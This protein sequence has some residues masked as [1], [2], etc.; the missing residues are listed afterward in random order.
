MWKEALI[1]FG[2]NF[3]RLVLYTIFWGRFCPKK[4]GSLKPIFYFYYFHM[5]DSNP[6]FWWFLREQPACFPK[7][8]RPKPPRTPRFPGPSEPI[9]LRRRM[10][11]CAYPSPSWFVSPL[12]SAWQ[13]T[14]HRVGGVTSYL[15]FLTKPSWERRQSQTTSL[16]LNVLE[17]PK[18]KK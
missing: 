12:A 16:F 3:S 13:E 18:S 2:Y 11:S 5:F 4:P 9:C 7:Q 8:N 1:F 14:A 10:T 6:F 17:R 15:L